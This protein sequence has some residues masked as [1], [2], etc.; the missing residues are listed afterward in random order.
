MRKHPKTRNT[1]S[2]YEQSDGIYCDTIKT[3]NARNCPTWRKRVKLQ[4]VF[5]LAKLSVTPIT[6]ERRWTRLFWSENV[7]KLWIKLFDF[8]VASSLI[9]NYIFAFLLVVR[10]KLR[11]Q[12]QFSSVYIWLLCTT[13]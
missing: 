8:R 9:K 1:E 11:L 6:Y 4:V 5:P 13:H 12:K 10:L 3:S 2:Y 7:W